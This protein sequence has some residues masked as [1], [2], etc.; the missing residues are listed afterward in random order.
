MSPVAGSRSGCE[1]AR[2]GHSAS[3]AY[4]ATD[5]LTSTTDRDGRV[6]NLSYDA[7]DRQTGETWVTSGTTVNTLTY[8]FDAAGNELTAADANGAY[9]M[10]YDVLN[11]MT[12][13]QEPYGQALT[14]TFDA[15][16]NRATRTDSQSGVATETYD[17]LNRLVTYQYLVSGVAKI[18]F[19]QT[20]TKRDQLNTQSRYS[21]LTGT[22]TRERLRPLVVVALAGQPACQQGQPWY[23][24]RIKASR[25]RSSSWAKASSSR[26]P[27][28]WRISCSLGDVSST[29]SQFWTRHEDCS[30]ATCSGSRLTSGGRFR[31]LRSSIIHEH[32]P[33][34]AFASSFVHRL[35]PLKVAARFHQ[36]NLHDVGHA[37]LL[38]RARINMNVL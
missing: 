7:L 17:A 11:R 22:G 37:E 32:S 38:P 18:S 1:R 31:N 14:F 23:F 29:A 5:Q 6:R 15:A 13:E 9:T 26:T 19:D 10:G 21:D 3:F 27:S 36:R 33:Q 30:A 35:D 25:W 4:S 20:W 24:W 8:A 16:S 28:S 12:S 2:V 34:P